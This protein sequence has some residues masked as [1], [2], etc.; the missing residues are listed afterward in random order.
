MSNQ[1]QEILDVLCDAYQ[2]AY[3]TRGSYS[4]LATEIRQT[5]V[6]HFQTAGQNRIIEMNRELGKGALAGVEA[7]ADQTELKTF[8][9]PKARAAADTGKKLLPGQPVIQPEHPGRLGRHLKASLEGKPEPGPQTLQPPLSETENPKSG[10]AAV[11]DPGNVTVDPDVESSVTMVQKLTSAEIE[12]IG[13]LAPA[14]IVS[15]YGEQ[16]IKEKLTAHMIDHDINAK[17]N[18]LAAILKAKAKA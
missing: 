13:K 11:D 14:E 7:T 8:V 3:K 16:W 18:K 9:H 15:V 4:P 10:V 17:P 5:I 2:K 12:S 6:R 1:E